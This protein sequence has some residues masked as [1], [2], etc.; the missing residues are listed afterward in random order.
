MADKIPRS[1]TLHLNTQDQKLATLQEVIAR[2]GG[3]AGCPACGRI[4]VLHVDILGDPPPIDLS[5]IGVT[6]IQLQH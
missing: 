3:I 6:A 2:I 5:K 1:V 4:A